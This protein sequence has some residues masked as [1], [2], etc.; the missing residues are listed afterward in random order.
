MSKYP[1]GWAQGCN[2]TAALNKEEEDDGSEDDRKPAARQPRVNDEEP[3]RGS[4]K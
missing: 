3:D 1:P 2:R 4:P